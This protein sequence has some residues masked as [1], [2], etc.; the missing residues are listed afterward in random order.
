MFSVI[1]I[2]KEY[3]TFQD[4]PQLALT[5]VRLLGGVSLVVLLITEVLR[6]IRRQPSS[7]QGGLS[8]RLNSPDPNQAWRVRTY[9]LLLFV[10]AVAAAAAGVL[11]A[12]GNAYGGGEK[13]PEVAAK[14]A[15]YGLTALTVAA[16]A[17]LLAVSWEFLLDLAALSP[18]RIW[19]IARFSVTEAVRRKALWSFCV[20]LLVFLFASWFIKTDNPE[21][22]W[23]VYVNLIFFVVTFLMLITASVLA[24]FSL[25]TDI[26]QQTIHTVVTKPVQRFE[27][28][29]GRVVGL[30]LLMTVVL[31]V[32]AHLSLL[33][34]FRG[35]DPAFRDTVLRARVAV[36]GDLHF[37]D[38]DAEGRWVTQAGTTNIG[39]E[40][41]YRKFI[42]GGSTQQAVWV[43]KELPADLFRDDL[44]VPVEFEF[45]IF[46][47]S[48][49]GEDYKEGVSC[50]FHFIN[51]NKWD[52][53]K[54]NEYREAVDPETR[55]PLT[56]QQRAEKYGY[57]ELPA[58]ITVVDYHTTVVH[59]PS[60]VLKDLGNGPFE[61][62]V[63]CRSHSQYLGM[64]RRDLYVL[65]REGNFYLNYL[66]GMSGIWFVTLLV[67]TLGVVFS[68]YLNALVDLF[69]TWLLVVCGLP[70]MRD[71]ITMLASATNPDDNP[72]GGPAESLYRLIRR[73]NIIAPLER[74][75][76]VS[77][78]EGADVGF[79][80]LFKGLLSVLPDLGQYDRSVFIAEGFNVPAAGIAVSAAILL[81]YLF[82]F[83]LLG[84]YLMSAR[85]IAN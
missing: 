8:G 55:L 45:D 78:V 65:A 50:Q 26:K 13:V 54:Y 10:A 36:D 47:T 12:W 27:V 7:W 44:M 81:I 71:F 14:V 79:R 46:R 70:R 22:Q 37:E 6:L 35:I 76:G 42:R 51:T 28:V 24:C 67:L 2:E 53:A 11:Y 30:G 66:K 29:L 77:V 74:T 83:L 49:G 84:Y 15:G 43:F 32:V 58:P 41:E 23:R 62:R 69:L 39:R 72:G 21:K 75:T 40:W 59:F 61:I 9:R 1:V 80:V 56:A 34:V 20:L 33:Y 60:S 68:T 16:A 82:P 48:K 38:L 85:E 18:R 63:N 4:L 17:A 64:A 25:P 31:L 5:W 52:F 3:A 73:E 19:A 57:Y